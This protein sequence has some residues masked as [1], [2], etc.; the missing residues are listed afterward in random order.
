TD[1][2]GAGGGLLPPLSHADPSYP[3]VI[4][5]MLVTLEPGQVSNP[6]AIENG[7]AILKLE[8]KIAAENVK[9]DDVKEGL[10]LNVRRQEEQIQMRQLART[11]LAQAEVVVLDPTLKESWDRQ[12]EQMR[13]NP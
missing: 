9:F 4:R 2:S 6:V 5:N 12:M 7:Y 11:L 1:P 3:A 8:R 13:S 10:S